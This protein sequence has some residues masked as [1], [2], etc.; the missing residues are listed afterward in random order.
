MHPIIKTASISQK[1]NAKKQHDISLRS[2][3]IRRRLEAE[4]VI[5]HPG[6]NGKIAETARQIKALGDRR[7][8]IENKPYYGKGENLICNGSSPEDILHIMS[9]TGAGF[10]LR[11]RPCHLFRKREG[12]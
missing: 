7:I 5:F 11:F 12:L 2:P 10:C 4:T 8:I 6:V 9:E 1:G 3:E